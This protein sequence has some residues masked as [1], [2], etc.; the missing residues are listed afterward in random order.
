MKYDGRIERP[1]LTLRIDSASLCSP[2][3]PCLEVVAPD[4]RS[5]DPASCR[6]DRTRFSHLVTIPVINGRFSV[7]PVAG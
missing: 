6:F 1:P 2:D 7:R 3:R 5:V 4:G